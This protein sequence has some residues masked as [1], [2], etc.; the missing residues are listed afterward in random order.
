MA[1]PSLF[2]TTYGLKLSKAGSCLVITG[3]NIKE[4]IPI[5][6]FE[7]VFILSNVTVTSQTLKFLSQHKK[8]VFFI[9]RTGKLISMV[10]PEL[11][12][13]ANNKRKWQYAAF[14]NEEKRIALTKTLLK[15]KVALV[16]KIR[17]NIQLQ[18][19]D[20]AIGNLKQSFYP[21]IEQMNSISSLM[22]MDGNIN[23]I[24]FDDLSA[25]LDKPWQFKKREFHPPKD[26]VNAM[27]SIVYTMY[28]SIL[29]P[30]I[31]S[32]GYDPYIGF[33][34]QKRGKHAALASDLIELSRPA[35]TFF[36]LDILNS[37][38]FSP[39]DFKFFK[40]ACFLKTNATKVLCKLF[41]EKILHK[42]L[43]DTNVSFMRRHFK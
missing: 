16:Q 38:Y 11:L 2:I 34:H 20:I 7:H 29:I 28:Y 41:A 43:T 27:L 4:K 42:N 37:H 10:I 19:G 1:K 31:L 8:Y 5:S 3:E 24:I 9:N 35:L 33:F 13:S 21:L 36:V 23:R 12:P 22:A 6:A 14:S 32:E 40:Q 30:V 39:S 17:K 26:E 15:E 25:Y 18:I